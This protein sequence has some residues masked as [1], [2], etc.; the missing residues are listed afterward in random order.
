MS[1]LGRQMKTINAYIPIAYQIPGH[2]GRKHN[3]YACNGGAFTQLHFY[4]SLLEMKDI[5]SNL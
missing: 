2:V 1:N 4:S 5:Q 3:T